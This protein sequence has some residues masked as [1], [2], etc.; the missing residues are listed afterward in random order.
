MSPGCSTSGSHIQPVTAPFS[1]SSARPASCACC[2]SLAPVPVYDCAPGSHLFSS[3]FQLLVLPLYSH[4]FSP[5]L[6]PLAAPSTTLVPLVSAPL[7]PNPQPLFFPSFKRLFPNSCY[8]ILWG[9]LQQICF[10]NPA[11]SLS[12]HMKKKQTAEFCPRNLFFW[13]KNCSRDHN[14]LPLAQ[15]E[16]M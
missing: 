3:L 7:Q 1:S 5:L 8:P 9:D 16:S 12:L 11:C 15:I 6:A 13:G 2:P 4:F 14:F 10:T